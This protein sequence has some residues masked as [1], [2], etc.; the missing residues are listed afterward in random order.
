M[1][2][3]CI[4]VEYSFSE[5]EF[6]KRSYYCRIHSRMVCITISTEHAHH[7]TYYMYD[8]TVMI[9]IYMYMHMYYI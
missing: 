4:L 2:Q 9:L 6:Q 5:L 1:A 7:T 3:I 8:G